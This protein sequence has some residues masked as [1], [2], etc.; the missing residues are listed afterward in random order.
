[1]SIVTDAFWTAVALRDLR[2]ID[3]PNPEPQAPPGAEGFLMILNWIS[4]IVIICAVAGFLISVGM[5]VFGAITGR[6]MQGF[7]G[8]VIAIVACIL[9]GAVG[10]IL[11]VFV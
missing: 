4:W 8:I 9:A 6:E 11:Q 3:V 7:K 1:M 10:G 5:L 2:Q